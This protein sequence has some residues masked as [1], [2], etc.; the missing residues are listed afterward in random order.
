MQVMKINGH[1]MG[2]AN[3]NNLRFRVHPY[4]RKKIG[5]LLRS[6]K[7]DRE[8]LKKCKA[9]NNIKTNSGNGKGKKKS[10]GSKEDGKDP[11]GNMPSRRRR[12][13]EGERKKQ[14]LFFK[15]YFMIFIVTTTNR[16]IILFTKW[17][18]EMK[19]Y[20]ITLDYLHYSLKKISYFYFQVLSL[21]RILHKNTK[22]IHNI[23]KLWSFF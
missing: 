12:R 1:R 10:L 14:F 8:A 3:C 19:I 11:R 7:E 15:K 4:C 13:G 20:L 9:L 5:G 2:I 23:L 17:K 16:H 21:I 18:T 22:F 6:S